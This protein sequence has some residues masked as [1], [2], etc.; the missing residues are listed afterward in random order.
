ME[1]SACL[2]GLET[3]KYRRSTR[4]SA[5]G[6]PLRKRGTFLHN[7]RPS[8]INI[9]IGLKHQLTIHLVQS[10]SPHLNWIN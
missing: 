5:T 8:L 6:L 1:P 7:N 9:N 10:V 4:R 2:T 3:G